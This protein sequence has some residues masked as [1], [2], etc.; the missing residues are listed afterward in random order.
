MLQTRICQLLGI[1]HPIINAPMAETATAQLAAAVSAAGGLGMIGAGVLPDTGWLRDQIQTVK[2]LTTRP[3]GVGFID[4][5][6]GTQQ[7]V[8]VALD[9]KVAAV[10]HSFADPTPYVADAQAHGIKVLAQVQSVAQAIV[11]AAGRAST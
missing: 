4:S 9:E 11:A 3:F 5:A 7:A 1:E 10:S 2:E 6:P 8:E